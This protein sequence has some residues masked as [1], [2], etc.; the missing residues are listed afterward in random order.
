VNAIQSPRRLG[1]MKHELAQMRAQGSVPF[2]KKGGQK[3]WSNVTMILKQKLLRTTN[4]A[5]D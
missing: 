5:F 2:V 4:L 1:C 3:R